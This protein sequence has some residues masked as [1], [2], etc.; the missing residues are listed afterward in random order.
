MKRHK[1]LSFFTELLQV[2]SAAFFIHHKGTRQVAITT[3]ALATERFQ[4]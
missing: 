2:K 1:P 3:I 4:G